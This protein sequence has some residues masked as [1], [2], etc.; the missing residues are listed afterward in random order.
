VG[1]L[2]RAEQDRGRCK[3]GDVPGVVDMQM[4]EPEVRDVA[5]GDAEAGKPGE[6]RGG[7]HLL[8]PAAGPRVGEQIRLRQP[9]VPEQETGRMRDQVTP[10]GPGRGDEL[11]PAPGVDELGVHR[12]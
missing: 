3:R 4:R 5:R 9:R 11:A 6:E 8:V 1:V 2:T 7:N 12:L 10:V